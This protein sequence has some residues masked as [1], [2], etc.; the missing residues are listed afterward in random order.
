MVFLF[1]GLV[2]LKKLGIFL[3]YCGI[4]V[5]ASECLFT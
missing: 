4:V 2:Y 1:L 3:G 5:E